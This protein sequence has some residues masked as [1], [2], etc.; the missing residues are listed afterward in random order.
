M[1]SFQANQTFT[2]VGYP[3]AT[4]FVDRMSES[5]AV[6]VNLDG[7]YEVV[8]GVQPE[9]YDRF[10]LGFFQAGYEYYVTMQQARV[11]VPL[12]IGIVRYRDDFNDEWSDIFVCDTKLNTPDY[13]AVYPQP[14]E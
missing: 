9:D 1:P 8:Y 6:G 13:P 2:K 7:T 3:Y 11:L 10:S 12:G 5:G 14:I 4:W